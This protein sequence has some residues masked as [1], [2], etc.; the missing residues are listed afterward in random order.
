MRPESFASESLARLL[1]KQKIATMAELKAALGTRVD[2]TVFRKLRAL[3]YLTS[4]S[5]AGRFYAL[6][7]I[8]EFDAQGLWS[9]DGVRFS[10]FGSLVDTAEHFVLQ[11]VGG[12]F[13]RELAGD[14]AVEVKDPL[15]KL[16]RTERIAREELA[17]RFLYCARNPARR[18][19]QVAIRRSAIPDEPFSEIPGPDADA[20]DETRAAIILFLS[21]LDEKRRRLFAGLESLRMGRGGDQR[22]A[23]WTGMDAHTVARGR[24]ELVERDL[25]LDRVRKPGGGRRAVEKKRPKSSKPSSD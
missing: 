21:S 11:A 18:R 2:M 5:H 4:Y 24:H 17:G 9:H 6:R 10:R 8:A 1:R 12:Y 3:D 13:A 23:E 14:L 16:V 19:R 15:L 7:Q 20:S 22:I 25:D